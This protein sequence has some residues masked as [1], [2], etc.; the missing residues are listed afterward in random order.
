MR[1]KTNLE[2]MQRRES[3]LLLGMVFVIYVIVGAVTE[4]TFTT[5]RVNKRS[6]MCVDTSLVDSGPQKKIQTPYP[7]HMPV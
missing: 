1:Q 3:T 7:Q 4:L 2:V 6:Y 5:A